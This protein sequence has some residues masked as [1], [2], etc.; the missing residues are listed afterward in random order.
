MLQGPYG[1]YSPGTVLP[2]VLR[3]N[4][5]R[6]VT[7]IHV[8]GPAIDPKGRVIADGADDEV[9]PTA[10]P[11]G[12]LAIGF[13]R[14]GGANF[15]KG[16]RFKLT[17]TDTPAAA[18][19]GSQNRST[20]RSHRFASRAGSHGHGV[21]T[22]RK[23]VSRPVVVLAACFDRVGRL[24]TFAKAFGAK[25]SAAAGGRI[26]FSVDFTR[27]GKRRPPAC[28]HLLASMTGYSEL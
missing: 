19:S 22:N 21:N 27:G 8:T 5:K 10:V 25:N 7:G 16:T 23:K 26:P 17:V 3:N 13:V 20:C 9:Q 6:T 2:V 12:G 4:T 18:T 24:V 11:P 14:F 1:S 15:P 28:R